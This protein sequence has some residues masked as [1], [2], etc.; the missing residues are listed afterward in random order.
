MTNVSDDSS[1]SA[2]PMPTFNTCVTTESSELKTV[3]TILL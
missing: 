1:Y 3:R 2:E